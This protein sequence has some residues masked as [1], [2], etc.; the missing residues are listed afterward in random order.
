[1]A[2]R[3]FAGLSYDAV[4]EKYADTVAGV[5]V[6]RLQNWADAEDC[7]QNTF[8]KLFQKSPDFKS[9]THLKAWLIR[10]AIN[11]CHNMLAK[12]RRF[13]PLD[14]VTRETTREQSAHDTAVWRDNERDASWALMRTEPKYREVLYL[15]YCE[16][17][18]VKEISEILG[19]N[20]NTVKT[21]LKRGREQLK[22]MYGG[23]ADE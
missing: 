11:E 10:V 18:K 13:L 17:Y 3:T 4:L 9:E 20:P 8:I 1:M 16:E 5:C 21:L 23:G 7:F 19:K 14:S 2:E 6:M 22:K 15:Y 12:N